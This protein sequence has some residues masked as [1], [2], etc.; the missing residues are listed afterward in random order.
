MH[1]NL[2]RDALFVPHPICIARLDAEYILTLSKTRKVHCV[3]IAQIN[4]GLIQAYH[5]VTIL[6][7]FW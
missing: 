4:P 2:H 1:A 7:L 6:I 3:L 5:L